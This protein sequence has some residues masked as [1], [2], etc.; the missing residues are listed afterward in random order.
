MLI[1]YMLS[2]IIILCIIN[3]IIVCRRNVGCRPARFR[4]SCIAISMCVALILLISS[5]IFTYE[6]AKTLG[7][8]NFCKNV[9]ASSTGYTRSASVSLLENVTNFTCFGPEINA[10]LNNKGSVKLYQ[11][12]CKNLTTQKFPI[13][14]QSLPYENVSKPIVVLSEDFDENYF[15]KGAVEVRVNATFD[16]V[17][18][19]FYVCLFSDVQAFSDFSNYDKDWKKYVEKAVQCQVT[20]DQYFT[21]TFA[22]ESPGYVF[23]GIASTGVLS[24]LQFS[25][26][27][28]GYNFVLSPGNVSE[29]CSLKDDKPGDSSCYFTVDGT[30]S[31]DLCILA[32]SVVYADGSLDYSTITLSFPHVKQYK[33]IGITFI[34]LA[35]VSTLAF[36]V[37]IFLIVCL[38][39]R[40]CSLQN[41][42]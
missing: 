4:A 6:T 29:V 30:A 34:A 42:S 16:L 7:K 21:T 35:V 38:G 37:L 40:R 27:G 41:K 20:T 5:I 28:T 24:T 39:T 3:V 1:N 12:E 22:I 9:K 31:R 11:A 26:N 2:Y 32:S 14:R 10:K 18:I 15:S 17:S 19:N 33:T 36:F 8:Y 25:Y 13:H 23:I